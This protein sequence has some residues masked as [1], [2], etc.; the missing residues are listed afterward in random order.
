MKKTVHAGKIAVCAVVA[1]IEAFG[2]IAGGLTFIG[3]PF[4]RG[5]AHLLIGGIG[6]LWALFL[7][8]FLV[9]DDCGCGPCGGAGKTAVTNRK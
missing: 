2:L 4:S 7:A 5:N 8:L 3:I 9:L 6:I 1:L